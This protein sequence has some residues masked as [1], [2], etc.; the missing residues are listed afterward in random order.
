VAAAAFRAAGESTPSATWPWAGELLSALVATADFFP[1][2]GTERAATAMTMAR[3]TSASA[4][5]K[6]FLLFMSGLGGWMRS[7]PFESYI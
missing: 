3:K 6:S 7:L 1:R 2:L 5:R 4:P